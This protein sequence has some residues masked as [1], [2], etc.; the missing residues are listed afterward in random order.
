MSGSACLADLVE[1]GMDLLI[2][3]VS[4]MAGGQIVIDHGTE[5]RDIPGAAFFRWETEILRRHTGWQIGIITGRD[6]R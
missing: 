5:A 4:G 3:L 6:S 1:F 2:D